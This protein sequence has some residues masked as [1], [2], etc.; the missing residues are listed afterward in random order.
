[1]TDRIESPGVFHRPHELGYDET[2]RALNQMLAERPPAKI[3]DLLHVRVRAFEKG[4]VPPK[5]CIG[6]RIADRVRDGF[7]FHLVEPVNV[8]AEGFGLQNLEYICGA[9]LT[10]REE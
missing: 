5:P 9:N 8:V 1:A 2:V 3:I 7:R 4:N 10:A 6:A